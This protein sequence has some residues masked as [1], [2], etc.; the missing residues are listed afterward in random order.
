MRTCKSIGCNN[1]ILSRQTFDFCQSCYTRNRTNGSFEGVPVTYQITGNAF[2]SGRGCSTPLRD[3]V[4][5]VRE[6]AQPE[7]YQDIS[8]LQLLDINR[9]LKLF[10]VTDPCIQFATRT[11]LH[12]ELDNT[13]VPD[14]DIQAAIESLQRWQE[15]RQEDLMNQ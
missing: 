12:L 1:E 6:P 2:G 15:M 13:S 4:D 8:G 9:V 7:L 14:Q 5:E 11:L 10:K 3:N